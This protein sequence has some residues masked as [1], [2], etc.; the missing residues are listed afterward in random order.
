M[1]KQPFCISFINEDLYFSFKP[2]NNQGFIKQKRFKPFGLNLFCFV[3]RG[4][5]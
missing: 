4:H 5:A 1:I 3:E 2:T